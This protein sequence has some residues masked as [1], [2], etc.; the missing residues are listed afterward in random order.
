MAA[1]QFLDLEWDLP[2][3]VRAA[4]TLRTA[5]ASREPC[6][7]F[8]TATHVGDDP[9]A[10]ANNRAALR[11]SL[12]LPAEPRWLEQTHGIEVYDLD[13]DA[14]AASASPPNADAVVTTRAGRVC[15]VQVADCLPVL[16]VTRDGS[17]IAAAHAGWRGLAQGV[18]EA[19]VAALQ[20]P[21]ASL[22]A[23]FG[24]S[25]AQQHFEVGDDV[26]AAFLQHS[27]AAAPA[28]VRNARGRWQCDLVGLARQR[29]ESLGIRDVS[30]GTWCTFA[31]AERFFSHRRDGR[32]GRMAALIW[33][34]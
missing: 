13:R 9:V 25:I 23:W 28:F 15:V 21:A 3:G 17:R 10:V 20:V 5:G 32:T 14:S 8:N 30:G 6:A 4:F 29:I 22:R 1:P 18:L 31:D 19:T 33:R 12:Q 16:F 26:R 24:P 11:A 27:P 2:L 7:S 34:T